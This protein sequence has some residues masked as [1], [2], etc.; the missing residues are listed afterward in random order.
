MTT[1]NYEG[2]TQGMN[3]AEAGA[4]EEWKLQAIAAV[5]LA[6]EMNDEFTTDEVWAILEQNGYDRPPTP[7]A[8]GPVMRRACRE[9]LIRK[10]G[11][12]RVSV[13][14]TNHAREVAVWVRDSEGAVCD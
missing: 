12:Y 9:H 2:K 5:Q 13:Q 1:P 6:S 8:M 11:R 10:T 14:H 4:P 7:A 3:A